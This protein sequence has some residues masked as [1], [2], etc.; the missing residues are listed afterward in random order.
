MTMQLA[1]KLKMANYLKAQGIEPM[2]HKVRHSLTLDN[3]VVPYPGPLLD[4]CGDGDLMS[5]SFTGFSP[6][7]DWLGWM[8]TDVEV[9]KKDFLSWVRPADTGGGAATQGWLADPCADPYSYEF[10]TCDFTLTGY[11]RIR[12]AG[13]TRELNKDQTLYCIQQPR[14]RLDGSPVNTNREWDLIN[15]TEVILQDLQKMVV[16]GNNNTA[17]QFD[18]L[19]VL[20]NNGYTNSNGQRCTIMDS[21]VIEWNSNTVDGGAGITWNGTAIASTYNL[22]DVL[23]Q[24]VRRIKWRIA[25]SPQLASRR[26]NVGDMILMLPSAFTD[27]ILRAYTCWSVC[28][29]DWTRMDSFEARTFYNGLLGGMFGFGE[30]SIDN[31]RIPLMGYDWDTIVNDTKFDMFVLTNQIGGIRLIDG[32]YRNM[33]IVAPKG[34]EFSSTDRG[35]LLSWYNRDNTCEKV[36]VEMNPRLEMM[37]PWA[38]ARIQN[39]TCT[40]PGGPWSVDPWETSFFPEQSFFPRTTADTGI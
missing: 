40:I 9:V 8:P 10:G 23:M 30:I 27:C 38:Q 5:L 37:G 2:Q 39:I 14:M 20:V 11:G 6:F 12:R 28:A 7:L 4:L 16:S 32:Q 35:L 33:N 22:I 24:I 13:P 18:G 29:N 17:G 19:K 36:L 34:P 3:T 21:I 31:M 15:A 26:M 25:H 1:S